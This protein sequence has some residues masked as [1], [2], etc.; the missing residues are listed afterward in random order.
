MYLNGCAHPSGVTILI[1]RIRENSINR[2]L[3]RVEMIR[4]VLN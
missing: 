4:V 3:S 2:K 1:H